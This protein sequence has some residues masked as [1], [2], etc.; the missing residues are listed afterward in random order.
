[1]VHVGALLDELLGAGPTEPP[2]PEEQVGNG[3]PTSPIAYPA[4]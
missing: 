3:R 4:P 1:M 2:P